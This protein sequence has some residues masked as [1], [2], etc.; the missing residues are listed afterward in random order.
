VLC[1]HVQVIIFYNVEVDVCMVEFITGVGEYIYTTRT[2]N[3]HLLPI[4]FFD[5]EVTQLATIQVQITLWKPH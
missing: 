5:L 1:I 4:F 3:V 2:C